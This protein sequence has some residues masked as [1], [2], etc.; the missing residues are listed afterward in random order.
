[1][2][3]QYFLSAEQAQKLGVQ[4]VDYLLPSAATERD[5]GRAL[6]ELRGGRSVEWPKLAG[7]QGDGPAESPYA[8]PTGFFPGRIPWGNVLSPAVPTEGWRSAGHAARHVAP[9]HPVSRRSR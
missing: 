6:R 5:A 9:V 4:L 3:A 8:R 7:I 1:M 2:E